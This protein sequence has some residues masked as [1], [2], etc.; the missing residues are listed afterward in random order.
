MPAVQPPSTHRQVNLG[1]LHRLL[2]LAGPTGA[3]QL[4]AALIDDIKST[5]TGLERAWSGPDYTLLRGHSHVLIALAGT[6]GDS[7][8]HANA[9]TLN[10]ASHDQNKDQIA[11]MTDVIMAQTASLIDHL[12]QLQRAVGA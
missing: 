1:P 3:A 6:V 8:L 2:H 10:A 5:Q 9:Q 4:L 11:A 12:M 7:D